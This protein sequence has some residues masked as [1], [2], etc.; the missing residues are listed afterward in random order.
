MSGR[1]PALLVALACLLVAPTAHA[2][3]RMEIGLEDERI[4]LDEPDQAPAVVAQW[5][6]LGV[7]VVRLH[8][9]WAHIAPAPRAT[10]P[11]AGFNAAN[12]DDP[13]YDWSELD[14]AVALLRAA[15]IKVALTVTGPGPVWS[16][17]KP[18]RHDGRWMPRASA[19]GAFAR[20]VAR[21]YRGQIS[22][23]MIWN[24]PNIPGWLS[25]QNECHS[26][27]V[28]KRVTTVC[29]PV[30]PHLYRALV[31]AAVPAIHSADPGSTVLMGELAPIGHVAH[32]K[33]STI[34]PFPFYRAL[35]CVDEQ[36]RPLRTGPCK[37][38][39]PAAADGI[40]HHPHGVL[41]SP[42]EPSKDKTWAKMGDLPR[43]ERLLDRLSARGRLKLPRGRVPIHLTE[44]G[45]QTSPPDHAI[46]I[47]V[48]EQSLWLQQA[49]YL[50]WRDPHVRSLFFYQW[51]DE[52]V[53]YRGPGTPA[54]SGWQSGLLYVNGEPKPALAS[55]LAPLVLDRKPGQ[56]DA[57]AWGQVRPGGAH[58]VTLERQSGSD[59]EPV[60]VLKTDAAGYF[61][62]KLAV[63]GGQR[64]RFTWTDPP[65]TDYGP[66]P[67]PGFSGVASVVGNSRLHA[68]AA[69]VP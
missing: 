17:A 2:A 57:V 35:A 42:D 20:A 47:S 27:R 62:R 45:Y 11:P 53:R 13:H 5:Q 43:F 15:G 40:G 64:Y 66:P 49:S 28:R 19:F 44:F 26:V 7:D 18:T 56:A 24:E 67:E 22:R 46:G 21:R 50:A 48:A 4:M 36:D 33:S 30:A 58:A 25:P 59:W 38:F 23:Y 52:P 68:A 61:S 65:A 60:D 34:A 55:F 9:R 14:P 10:K 29:T 32:S 31:R 51:E 41:Q 63:A 39:R 12:P 37:G 3:A 6:S 54:Y 1:G 69:A 16:S 8:A